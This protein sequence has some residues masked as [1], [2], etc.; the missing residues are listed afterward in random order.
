[1]NSK[2]CVDIFFPSDNNA[3]S[4]LRSRRKDSKAWRKGVSK[5]SL[6]LVVLF[7]EGIKE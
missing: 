7:F 1:M 4:N 5:N 2:K 6:V 3:N